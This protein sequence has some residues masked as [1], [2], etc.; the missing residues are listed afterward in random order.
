MADTKIEWADSVWNP[1]VGCSVV[2]PGCTNCYAMKQAARIERMNAGRHVAHATTPADIPPSVYDG[3]TR[4]TKAG[5]VWTG[6]VRR[7][8]WGE[9]VVPYDGERACRV[10]GCTECWACEPSSCSWVERDLCSECRGKVQPPER[11]MKF[12][13]LGKTRAGRLLDGRSH[14]AM[15]KETP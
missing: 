4:Q 7:A 3:L 9:F 13:R 14:S 2:S 12:A 10:C 1:V 11:A 5:A 8:Q 15:P 6:E